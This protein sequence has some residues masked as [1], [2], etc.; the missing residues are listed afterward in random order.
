MVQGGG[1]TQQP[2]SGLPTSLSSVVSSPGGLQSQVKATQGPGL[3][4]KGPP[5]VLSLRKLN[6]ETQT[7]LW[8]G[9]CRPSS[10]AKG[11]GGEGQVHDFPGTHL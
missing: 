8:G 4:G 7:S 6:T 5:G 1:R 10:G 2:N 3:Y 9:G 11:G